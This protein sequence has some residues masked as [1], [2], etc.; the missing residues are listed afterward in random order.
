MSW[1][2]DMAAMPAAK[3]EMARFGITLNTNEKNVARGIDQVYQ[4]LAGNYPGLFSAELTDPMEQLDRIAQVRQAIKPAYQNSYG[5]SYEK[6]GADLAMRIVGSAV[7]EGV[8]DTGVAGMLRQRIDENLNLHRSGIQRRVVNALNEQA[9]EAR[10][11]G[12]A[13]AQRIVRASGEATGKG[14]KRSAR[15]GPTR[16]TLCRKLWPGAGT[17]PSGRGTPEARTTH[18]G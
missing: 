12:F 2:I 5:E 15:R 8:T 9:R 11:E 14:W 6:R 10:N 13:Q 16:A 4:E 3:R 17:L 18:G 7:A 1:S